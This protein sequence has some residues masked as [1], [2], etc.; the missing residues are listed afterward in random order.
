MTSTLEEFLHPDL[1]LTG[2]AAES[3]EDVVQK[4][5]SLLVEKGYVEEGYARACLERE[6]AFP[7]G[8]PTREVQVAIPHTE[9]EH[10][11]KP[12]IAVATLAQSVE[13]GEMA[14][15]D[16]L[17]NVDVVF[18]LSITDP[19]DQV[20]WLKK[21]ILMFERPGLL[22][23]LKAVPDAQAC[24]GFLHRELS[25]EEETQVQSEESQ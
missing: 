16:K 14:T 17:L 19:K 2:L 25:R 1:I 11:L 23:R 6:K 22:Q 18:A 3:K 24:Y 8:L 15:R 10:C 5:G 21:L 4:L 7:T 9:A 13:F 12:G 20:K